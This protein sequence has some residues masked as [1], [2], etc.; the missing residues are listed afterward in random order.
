MPPQKLSLSRNGV[1]RMKRIDSSFQYCIRDGS[2]PAAYVNTVELCKL[3][4][5]GGLR[6]K[7]KVL[8]VQAKGSVKTLSG[9][10]EEAECK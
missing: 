1:S 7:T 9:K 5:S 6:S 4:A 3:S 10:C 8:N 2:S